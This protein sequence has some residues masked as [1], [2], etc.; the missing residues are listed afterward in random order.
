MTQRREEF[1]DI[2]YRAPAEPFACA[3]ARI[4]ADV[5]GVDRVG[6]DDSFYDFGGTSIQA[7]RIC[8]RVE[9]ETGH[10]LT[11]VL[12]FEHE[13]LADLLDDPAARRATAH[14]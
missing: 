10:A 9:Q 14:A 1:T 13:V 7:I 8:V 4:M 2:P 5:L 6:L 3:V 12:L 11:P